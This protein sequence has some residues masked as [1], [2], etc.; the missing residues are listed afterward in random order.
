MNNKKEFNDGKKNALESLKKACD[1]KKVDDEILLLLHLINASSN[2]YTSSSCAGRIAVLEIPNIGNKKEAVF[3]GKW[4]RTIKPDEIISAA[5]KANCGLLWLL[6]QSPIFHIVSDTLENADI[7]V[8]AA[9][10]CGFKN[11]GFKSIGKKIVI[12]ICSTER[13]DAPVG[14]DGNLFCNEEYLMLLVDICNEVI[15]KSKEKLH[16]FYSKMD[17]FL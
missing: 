4:H 17:V 13:L 16:Q 9:I 8:K 14:Q 3:L 7:M 10:A 2:Y 5:E 12:E 6:A 1:L 11:S 15:V